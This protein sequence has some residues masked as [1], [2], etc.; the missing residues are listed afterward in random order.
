MNGKTQI[1]VF[2]L[3]S[4]FLS[5]P[6]SA[7]P[8][9]AGPCV[10]IVIGEKAPALE[11]LAVDELVSQLKR[12]YEADVKISSTAPPDASHVI[13]VGSPETNASMKTFVAAWPSGDKKL[14]EQ[15]HLLRSV[16][17]DSKPAL[18][19]GGGSP[20]ATFWAVAEYG[21]QLG[22]RPMFFSD[23]DPVSPPELR[24]DGFDVV[25][26]PVHRVRGWEFV[27]AD[28]MTAGAWGLAEYRQVL[29]QLA[30][31]KFNHVRL[32]LFAGEPWVQ[33]EF[34]GV[35]SQSAALW[36]GQKFPVSGD[37]LGRKPF[38][39]AKL[40]ENPDFIGAKSHADRLAAGK[41]W[42]TGVIDA[43]HEFGLAVTCEIPM[44]QFPLDFQSLAKPSY[45]PE[46]GYLRYSVDFRTQADD[47]N[48]VGVAQAQWR[49]YRENYPG[50]DAFEIRGFWK[51]DDR[52]VLRRLIGDVEASLGDQ[53]RKPILRTL[54]RRSDVIVSAPFDLGSEAGDNTSGIAEVLLDRSGF[55]LPSIAPSQL[56]NRLQA[57]LKQG[58]DG[59][60][61]SSANI[62][63]ADLPAYWLSRAS[64]GETLSP[65]AALR[66]FVEPAC[67]D[68]VHER[69]ALAFAAS[70]KAL[71]MI[72]AS[73][74]PEEF[75]V[76]MN[77]KS[78]F[79]TF[80]KSQVV[81]PELWAKI[82][83]Q[84]LNAM[85]EMYRANTRA[86]EG[87]RAFSL[88]F[89]R[90]FEFAYEYMGAITAARNAGAADWQKQHDK[91]VPN[92]ETAIESLNNG[93]NAMAAIARSNSDR[94][95]IAVLNEYGYR[96][97]KKK[98]AEAEAA[99][100]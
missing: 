7:S 85:N 53:D 42:L 37:T 61:V 95:L 22:I 32:Y 15:G 13:F 60:W 52:K 71:T 23:L 57:A 25:L 33:V 8:I 100:K 93:L 72:E 50:V 90:R 78:S 36:D 47:R 40:F 12:V 86:R 27:H 19:V 43:A 4:F 84:Y 3:P 51:P 70:E 59:Y 94:G 97:I 92:L 31:R 56:S 16:T 6:F 11:R 80:L 20:A 1:L 81:A 9:I 77:M 74:D 30:K 54:Q 91:V 10:D 24:L 55:Y 65:D 45:R 99:A 26:E 46:P 34:G 62:G 35:K 82:Q 39:G 63:D 17:H 41:K 49:A 58:R 96:P 64:F 87:G 69:V 73:R 67:G 38:G 98:L 5:V 44:Y 48:V 14:T 79:P 89:A 76:G 68:G 75:T 21:H 29:R 83:E 18:L 88:Y 2:F 28:P 66:Q